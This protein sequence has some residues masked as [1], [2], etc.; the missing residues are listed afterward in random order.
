MLNEVYVETVD[1]KAIVAIRPKAAF[2]P[3]FEIATTRTGS[4]VGLI[5]QTPQTR[6]E[7]EA[8]EPCS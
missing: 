4:G 2:R 7:P 3:I 6:D 5:N 8:S 1:E